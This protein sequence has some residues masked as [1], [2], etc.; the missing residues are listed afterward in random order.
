MA[1]LLSPSVKEVKL[2]YSITWGDG[3]KPFLQR[4]QVEKIPD[5]RKT[6]FSRQHVLLIQNK[7]PGGHCSIF[8]IVSFQDAGPISVLLFFL[9]F[10]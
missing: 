4:R 6:L 8:E 5:E 2:L 7:D 3:Q 9:S 1:P 10:F